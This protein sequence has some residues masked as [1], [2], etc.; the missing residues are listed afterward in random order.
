[1]D[2]RRQIAGILRET[3]LFNE[4]LT[5]LVMKEGL[6]SIPRSLGKVNEGEK[7][8]D[9]GELIL[10][11]TFQKIYSYES[12]L[13]EREQ[14]NQSSILL[15]LGQVIFTMAAIIIII[16]AL[17]FFSKEDYA[18]LNSFTLILVLFLLNHVLGNVSVSVASI[19]IY[20]LPFVVFA[21]LLQ[22]FFRPFISSFI[23]A[24]YIISVAKWAPNPLEFI[25]VELPVGILVIIWLTEMVRRSQLIFIII[26]TFITSGILYL[27]SELM[28]GGNISEVHWSHFVWFGISAILAFLAIPLVFI[29]E[30]LFGLVSSISLLELSDTNNRMLR[31]LGELAPGTFQHSLQVANLSESCA[32]LIGGNSLLMRTGALYHDIGKMENPKFFIENQIGA[33]PHDDMSPEESASTIINH[34]V[35]GVELAR[36][37]R[38]P[39]AVIDFIR[40]HHGTTT[41]RYFLGKAQLK[42]PETP[43]H[44]FSY[45]GPKPFSKETAILMICDGVEAA[46]RSLSDYSKP[47]LNDLVDDIIEYLLESGQLSNAPI[48]LNEISKINNLLKQKLSSIYHGRIE[49]PGV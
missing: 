30:R 43:I 20:A 12:K 1:L 23:Y 32:R 37:N 7:I 22:T 14:G 21:I 26:A 49:Y 31:E 45:P 47:R 4:S 17:R 18:Q 10:D 24:M 9:K 44:D 27:A 2:A 6:H 16:L 33:N 35:R 15:L 40:T 34:V 36:K 19:S 46:S 11:K 42:D 41:T 38:L 3:L 28:S 48:T 13:K 29:V 8:V 5:N 25:W 39:E